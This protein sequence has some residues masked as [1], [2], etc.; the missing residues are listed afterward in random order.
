M[1]N[2]YYVDKNNN[3]KTCAFRS[4]KRF[5]NGDTSRRVFGPRLGP[6]I[7]SG[8]IWVETD[9]NGYWQMT[10]TNYIYSDK[11]RHNDLSEDCFMF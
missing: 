6:G 11:S 5:N 4:G 7:L 9:C 8:L 3:N 1:V 10:R 2:F